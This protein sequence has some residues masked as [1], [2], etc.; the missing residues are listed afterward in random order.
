MATTI[1]DSTDLDLESS[2]FRSQFY[3]EKWLVPSPSARWQAESRT[4]ASFVLDRISHW[5]HTSGHREIDV[6]SL[7]SPSQGTCGDGWIVPAC[8]WGQW[9]QIP[10]LTLPWN[11]CHLC[12]R[13]W[14]KVILREDQFGSL[15]SPGRLPFRISWHHSKC[16]KNNYSPDHLIPLLERNLNE[17]HHSLPAVTLPADDVLQ[18]VQKGSWLVQLPSPEVP[19]ITILLDAI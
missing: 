8:E 11:K 15:K 14:P 6:A 10:G 1:L 3:S 2:G 16:N 19:T 18:R 5:L 4:C 9:K 13:K 12:L 17:Q 7:T